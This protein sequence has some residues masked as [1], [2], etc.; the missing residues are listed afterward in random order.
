LRCIY[1]HIVCHKHWSLCG[2]KMAMTEIIT[3]IHC[4]DKCEIFLS[5]RLIKMSPL[6]L[7]KTFFCQY[8]LLNLSCHSSHKEFAESCLFIPKFIYTTLINV[9]FEHQ[10]KWGYDTS[11]MHTPTGMDLRHS[12]M[13]YSRR[14][15][16]QISFI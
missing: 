3:G 11:Y 9:L 2:K 4:A 1:H 7:L 8:K 15:L 10:L 14:I 6:H 12:F 13:H 5:L 16:L